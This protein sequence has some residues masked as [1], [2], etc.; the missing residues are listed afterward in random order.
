MKTLIFGEKLFLYLSQFL[1]SKK[2]NS[3]YSDKQIRLEFFY[4]LDCQ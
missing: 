2:K 1:E 3:F 4:T